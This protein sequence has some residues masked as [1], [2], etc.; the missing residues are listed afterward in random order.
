MNEEKEIKK[1]EVIVEKAKKV[2]EVESP[3]KPGLKS[4]H[5][6]PTLNSGGG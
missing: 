3:V 6:Q 4:K 1:D 2:K 5:V